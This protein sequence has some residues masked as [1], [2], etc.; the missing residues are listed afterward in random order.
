MRFRREAEKAIQWSLEMISKHRKVVLSNKKAVYGYGNAGND[1]LPRG[2][3]AVKS[4]RGMGLR[5]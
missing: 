4:E 3:E 1:K 5:Y 2:D